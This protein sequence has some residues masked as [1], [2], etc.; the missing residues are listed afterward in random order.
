MSKMRAKMRVSSVE[1]NGE[2]ETL[3]FSAVCKD[4][5][6]GEGGLDENNTFAKFTPT[7]NLSMYVNNPA[8]KGKF[9]VGEEYYLDFTE[10][11]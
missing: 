6:Y 1:E 9:K 7:A 10:A 3:N 4:E 8:L 2:G 5:A 11:N